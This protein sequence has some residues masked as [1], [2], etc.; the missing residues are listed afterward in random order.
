MLQHHFLMVYRNFRRFKSSFLINLVGLATG[1]ASAL[2]IFLWISDE[3]S[4]DKFFE[5]DDRI[6]QVLQNSRL[7]TGIQTMEATPGL[8]AKK[9]AD[10]YS[11]MFSIKNI[12]NN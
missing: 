6:F 12:K 10:N 11:K 2:L 5:N 1:L 8:L 9:F 7:E 4:V 3:L